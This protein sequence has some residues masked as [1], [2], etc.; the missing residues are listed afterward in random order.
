[1]AGNNKAIADCF[2]DS[3]GNPS[4]CRILDGGGK[5]PFS[6]AALT[7]LDSG[8]VRFELASPALADRRHIFYVQFAA[9]HD[10]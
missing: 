4:D 9:G 6:A 5:N 7:W 10:E 2:I 8:E 3:D 1:V